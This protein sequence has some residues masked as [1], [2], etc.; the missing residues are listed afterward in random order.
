MNEWD[1]NAR[2]AYAQHA[3]S[4]V[5]VYPAAIDCAHLAVEALI[6]FSFG[7]YPIALSCY[8]EK[9]DAW[10]T[11][12]SGDFNSKSAFSSAA[13]PDA[14]ELWVK[15]TVEVKATE[16]SPGDLIMTMR[17]NYSHGH[18][19]IVHSVDASIDPSNPYVVCYQGNLPIKIPVR[20]E[21]YLADIV[22]RQDP[23]DPKG[24]KTLPRRWFFD[25][26]NNEFRIRSLI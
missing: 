12:F 4:F 24:A 14:H 17:P 9:S 23:F 19:R 8:D 6:D 7:K 26:F 22:N 15:N 20:A 18:T 21:G 10:V 11:A 1:G 3:A 5:S 2:L 13:I 16:L 25:H